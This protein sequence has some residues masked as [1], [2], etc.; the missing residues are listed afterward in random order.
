[1]ESLA[2]QCGHKKLQGRLSL[3]GRDFTQGLGDPD[4]VPLVIRK[5]ITEIESRALRMKVLLHLHTK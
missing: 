4:G 2:I 3:F 5:C 1:M